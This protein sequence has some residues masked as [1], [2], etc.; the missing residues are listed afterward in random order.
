MLC[1]IQ[2]DAL[3]RTTITNQFESVLRGPSC[4][5]FTFQL[6]EQNFKS[7]S[8]YK[9]FFLNNS[10]DAFKQHF[11]TWGLLFLSMATK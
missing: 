10:F 3:N 11:V 5:L 9:V 7:R 6:T 1:Q 8:I 4:S 2:I